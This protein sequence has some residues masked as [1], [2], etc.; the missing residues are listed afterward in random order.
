MRR[1][2]NEL[3]LQ[4]YEI[5]AAK[6][7]IYPAR[8]NNVVYPVLGLVGEAGEIANKVKKIQRDHASVMTEEMRESLGQEIGD[9][10]W[11]LAALAYELDFEL[12]ALAKANLEKLAQRKQRGTLHGSGDN[13]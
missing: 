11:Y 6:T 3:R 7:A 2:T 1:E 12:C 9:C 5:E 13:R 4:A 8:G 10:L